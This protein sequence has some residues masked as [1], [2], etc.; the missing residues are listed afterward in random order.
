MFRVS[1][2]NHAILIY[3]VMNATSVT[4][5]DYN[6]MMTAVEA[7]LPFFQLE[8]DFIGWAL[9]TISMLVKHRQA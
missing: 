5:I 4:S 8:L 7:L 2:A 1:V 6:N 9:K 3:R